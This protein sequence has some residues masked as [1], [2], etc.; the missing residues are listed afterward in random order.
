MIW[1][2]SLNNTRRYRP[3]PYNRVKYQLKGINIPPFNNHLMTCIWCHLVVFTIN[4]VKILSC[5]GYSVRVV[6]F[7][8]SP[9]KMK[10]KYFV[11]VS[12]LA[13]RYKQTF[14]TVCWQNFG[15]FSPSFLVFV[16]LSVCSNKL[17]KLWS[18]GNRVE[19]LPGLHLLTTYVV[20]CISSREWTRVTSSPLLS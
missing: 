16:R 6:F 2:F 18:S 17:N 13:F 7:R 8:N 1:M 19:C 5:L 10:K 9:R 15:A 20:F 3:E 14:F 4:A 12:C 11:N